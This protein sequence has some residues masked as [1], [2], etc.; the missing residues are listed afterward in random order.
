M[1]NQHN[2]GKTLLLNSIT[3]YY[4]NNKNNLNIFI[5][6]L[7][8]NSK[9]S[10]RLIDWLVTNYS[11]TN[12]IQYWIDN[13]TTI[14]YKKLP[15]N[16]ELANKLK[17]FNLYSDYRAQ[18]KSFSKKYFD[19]FRRHERISYIINDNLTIQT[20]LG[21]LNFFKWFFKNNIYY[22]ILNNHQ[23]IINDMSLNSKNKTS[24]K[25]NIETI[26]KEKNIIRFD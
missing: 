11:K 6:I 13:K 7:N 3:N 2:I 5:D 16:F 19:P 22:Y 26:K 25:K 4:N 14:I 23:N 18:L 10:L 12:N 24:K 21:Q 17:K 15:N 8:G 20:T 1:E 9:I